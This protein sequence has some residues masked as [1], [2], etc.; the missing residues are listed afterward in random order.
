ML[1]SKSVRGSTVVALLAF[2]LAACSESPT[3]PAGISPEA[4]E[5]LMAQGSG[6][7]GSSSNSGSGSG[8]RGRE[9][10]SRAFTIWPGLPVF[11]KFGDHVL[12]MPA[13]VVC[14]PATSGYGAAFWDTRCARATQPIQVTA[15]W[16]TRSGRPAISFSPHVRFV[17]SQNQNQWVELSLRDTKGIKP[18]R[19]Y[20]I[21]WF[22]EETRRWVD[23]SQADPTLR[24]RTS[25]SGNLI[26]RRLK[27]F[28]EFALWSGLGSY[29]VTS[30]L[31]GDMVG[32]GGW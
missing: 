15:T 19:Y 12:Q 21:L 31:G 10:G 28:S 4:A 6:N 18:D 20:T 1:M 22:D 3:A 2:G 29:N 8:G 32:V 16:T 13:N 26:T 9:S 23:E 17:P 11:E 14:D 25:Q 27:H 7:S 5:P 30:G 24:A